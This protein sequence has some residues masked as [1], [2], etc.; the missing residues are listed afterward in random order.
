MD[1]QL[2]KIKEVISNGLPKYINR[3]TFVDTA[4][5]IPIVRVNG[6]LHLLFQVRSKKIRQ[7]GEICFPGGK[8]D[9]TIDVDYLET[10]LRETYE[11]IGVTKDKI[12]VIGNV[13]TLIGRN[14]VVIEAFIGELNI[15]GIEDLI[16]NTNE[17]EDVFTL[18]LD[19]FV[20]NKPD[21]YYVK[22]EI[23]P[24]YYENGTKKQIL[25]SK[26]LGL[27]KM[28]YKPWS[29][30]KQKIFVYKIENRV[31]WGI[32]GELIYKLVEYIN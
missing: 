6:E 7:G 32:T 16:I 9:Y 1:W 25:P 10:A 27:P 22:V 29:G 28:Y 19:Y 13:G 18:P 23:Q 17:V 2:E 21:C 20:N 15:N 11:E 8:H 14:G 30:K 31:I 4:V 3:D 26:E 5:L 24:Y 12:N